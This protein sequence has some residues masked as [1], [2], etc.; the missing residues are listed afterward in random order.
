MEELESIRNKKS[1]APYLGTWRLEKDVVEVDV[2]VE[3]GLLELLDVELTAAVDDDAGLLELLDVELTAD[4]DDDAGLLELLDV[5]LT[6]D[7]D[8]DAG[9]IELLEL[10]VVGVLGTELDE[11]DLA[12]LIELV[13]LLLNEL[14]DE[15]V[16]PPTSWAEVAMARPVANALWIEM[17]MRF[18]FRVFE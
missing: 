12:V 15:V 17:R 7:V 13:E 1:V 9:L 5:G 8:D 16:A 14:D 2:D 11:L 18:E 3:A 6:A 10:G 4:V